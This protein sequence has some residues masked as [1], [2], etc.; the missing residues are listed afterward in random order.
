MLVTEAMLNGMSRM[1]KIDG[2][3]VCSLAEFKGLSHVLRETV[4]QISH[5]VATQ[6]KVAVHCWQALGE[7]ATLSDWHFG[8]LGFA[9]GMG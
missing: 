2:V 9:L 8:Q 1:S 4:I 7:L 6:P 3:W 5:A